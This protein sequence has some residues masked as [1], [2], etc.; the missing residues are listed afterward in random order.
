MSLPWDAE[1]IAPNLETLSRLRR[2]DHLSV[3]KD[4][5]NTDGDTYTRGGRG[6]RSHFK[7]EGKFRQ[8]FVRT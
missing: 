8:A 1:N 5:E 3:L 4:G 2:G 6:L 7:I